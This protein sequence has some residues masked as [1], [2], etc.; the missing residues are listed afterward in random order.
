MSAIDAYPWLAEPWERLRCYI[1][2]GRVPQ[3]L[4]ITGT[5]GVGKALLAET[6]ARRLLC[7]EGGESA[8]GHCQSCVLFEAQTHPDY[9][10]VEPAE[11]GKAITVDTVRGLIATLSLKPQYSGRRVVILTPAEQMNAAAA[12]SLLKTLEEPDA[13]TT[14]LLLSE[15]P[16]QL[17]ATIRSRCQ[18]LEIAIPERQQALAWL[19]GNGCGDDASVLLS[20][21]RGAPLRALSFAASDVI[22]QRANFF[23]TWCAVVQRKSDPVTAAEQWQKSSCEQLVGWMGAWTVDLIR[24]RAAPG[25]GRIDNPDLRDGLQ[26]TAARLNLAALFR[27]LDL[28][29]ATR[30]QL[31][32]QVNRQM[33]LEELLIR[34]SDAASTRNEHT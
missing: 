14:L 18:R 2:T 12:N 20:L 11:P 24:L 13:H 23:R 22:T 34:W 29:N 16:E 3:G 7:R 17:P 26:A 5:T 25:C 8:C 27:Y 19:Q 31:G 6:F 32:G 33:V 21:A 15:A 9:L 10:R 4:L 1:E 30:R 28:L